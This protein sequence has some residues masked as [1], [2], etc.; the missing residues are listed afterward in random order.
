VSLGDEFFSRPVLRAFV[1]YAM[2]ANGLKG[3][4]GGTDYALDNEGWSWGVQMETWW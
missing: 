2:W 1:T 3:S 4:V